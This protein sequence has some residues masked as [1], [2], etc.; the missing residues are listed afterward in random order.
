MR[1]IGAGAIVAITVLG[2]AAACSARRADGDSPERERE[3]QPAGPEL[4][5]AS[6]SPATRAPSEPAPSPAAPPAIDAGNGLVVHES[7]Y[8]A[9]PRGGDQPFARLVR[10]RAGLSGRLDD[11]GIAP[12]VAESI[13]AWPVAWDRGEAIVLVHGG[14]QPNPGYRLVVDRVTR[15]SGRSLGIA[16]RIVPPP[17]DALQPQVLSHPCAVLRIAGLDGDGTEVEFTLTR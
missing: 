9:C 15:L 7:R 16:G 13:A 1:G 10:A 17:R 12:T 14:A 2:L 6:P 3:A 11:A 4:A 5:P 8:A